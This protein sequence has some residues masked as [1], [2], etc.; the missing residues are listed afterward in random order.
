MLKRQKT[1][2]NPTYKLYLVGT[3]IGNYKDIT[4]RAVET[5]ASSDVIYCEDTRIT[6]RLLA[7]YNI[8]TKLKS[9][10]LFNENEV[11]SSILDDVKK[12]LIVSIV[13]DAGMPGIS[14]PGYLAVLKSI[15]EEIN[16]EII[17]GV[18]ASITALV[19][20]G[21]EPFRFTFI[22][23]LNSNASK[24]EK[25]LNLLKD[26]E[27]PLILYEAPHRIEK[28]LELLDKIM[29][30]RHIVL[31]RELTKQYEEYLRGTPKEILEVVEEIK[32]EMVLIIS[33]Q[34]KEEATKDLNSL[35]IKE[36]YQYY[37]DLGHDSK[38]AMK[39]VAKD[40]GV[41]KSEIY[42]KIKGKNK[43]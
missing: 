28:T 35:T 10:H 1:N 23:F 17:P 41:S 27:L 20:S 16:V 33:A 19:G 29:P 8:K 32:G 14:D 12:G 21:I 11:T 38:E 37:I 36:H 26:N 9:Y 13:S 5:L 39:M 7:H 31:A 2:I 30:E 3:P 18:S 43:E 25:E 6:S 15:E 22:G 4:Y 42:Q 34:S 24:R 40:K